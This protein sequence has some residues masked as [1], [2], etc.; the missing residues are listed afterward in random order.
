MLSHADCAMTSLVTSY[1]Y[2]LP[3]LYICIIKDIQLPQDLHSVTSKQKKTEEKM[4][5][6]ISAI[7]SVYFQ[8]YLN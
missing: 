7:Q 1:L 5:T 6:L 3:C 8:T 2:L 4:K